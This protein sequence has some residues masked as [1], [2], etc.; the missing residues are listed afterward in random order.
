V[1]LVNGV[2]NSV[3]LNAGKAHVYGLE[4]ETIFQLAT[5]DRLEVNAD[6]LH[7]RFTSFS[8]PLGDSYSNA[9][10]SPT[11]TCVANPADPSCFNPV[12]YTGNKL[13]HSPE[14]NLTGTY[15]HS[16]VLS[17]GGLLTALGQVHYESAQALEYTN[18]ALT[19]QAAFT[20]SNVSLTYGSAEGKWSAQAYVHNIENKTVLTGAVSN[21][22]TSPNVVTNGDGTLAPPRTFGVRLAAKF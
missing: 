3:T 12:D 20:R 16:W 4:L 6:Y 7:G 17:S 14:I 8:L 15:S 11:P 18:F 21:P 13:P 19:N 10:L 5:Y 1:D 2:A 9:V 22:G